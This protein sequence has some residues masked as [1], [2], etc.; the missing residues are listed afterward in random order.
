[1]SQVVR[2][3]EQ[4][5]P[6]VALEE[7]KDLCQADEVKVQDLSQGL[8]PGRL[9]PMLSMPCVVESS[10]ADAISPIRIRG[11]VLEEHGASQGE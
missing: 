2:S 5:D 7:G 9:E 1:M 3:L 8:D 11:D 6:H 10:A 4:L